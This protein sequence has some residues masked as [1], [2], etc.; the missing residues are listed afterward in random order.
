MAE[1]K[2]FNFKSEVLID[3][4]IQEEGYSPD[5]FGKASGKFIWASC[6]FC[7][8]PS[9]IRKGFFNKAGSACH[10][11]CRFKEQSISGSPFQN[12]E[13]KQKAKATNLERYG[14]EFASQNKDVAKK[15]SEV[16]SSKENQD[17]IKATNMERYG[18]EN[19][20]QS[21]EIKD[22]IKNAL[23]DK[24]GV[25]HPLK[26]EDIKKRAFAKFKHTF[27]TD[28]KN[29]NSITLC[30]RQEDF[31]NKLSEGISLKDICGLFNISVKDTTTII[32]RKEFR[33]R[34]YSTYTFPK[35]QIQNEIRKQIEEL[36]IISEMNDKTILYPKELDIFIPSKN[37]AIEFNGSYWHSEAV[38]NKSEARQKHITKTKMCKEK[39]IRLFHIFEHTWESRKP[40][41]LG[42]IKSI[43]RVN[44]IKVP[45]RECS[46]NNLNI[47]KF[48]EDNHMQGHGARTIKFFNLE[49]DGEVVGSMTAAPHHR[50]NSSENAIV[51]NR[52]CFKDGY[53]V[54]GGSTKLFKSFVE[55]AKEQGYNRVISWSDNC[56]TEGNIYKVLGFELDK[57]YGPDY[58]YWDVKNHKY[59]SKQSQQ[60]KKTN[61]PDGLTER[62]WCEQRGL[63]RIWDCGKKLWTYNIQ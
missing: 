43:L 13:T 16:R 7:G 33:D 15:I 25:D 2:I 47:S 27:E 48:I 58:F 37:F 61:C 20:F 38:L 49:Y 19:P 32:S 14:S 50:Q 26:N 52:L 11:E 63:Y 57:E 22:K 18:V 28:P 41:I 12:E 51:L 30:L 36:G 62:E 9:R 42:F 29:E 1:R 5:K 23:I 56:W 31:W 35:H 53:N 40:Q 24:F 39:G 10:K 54:Q 55:W 45:A 3:K 44:N 21:E 4:T 46:I 60:K 34:Y 8:E 17:K 59:V 6:R